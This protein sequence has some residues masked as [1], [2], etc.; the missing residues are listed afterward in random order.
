[1]LILKIKQ[2]NNNIKIFAL[3]DD[4]NDKTRVLDYGAD[5]F[6]TKPISPT[7]TVEKAMSLV[8]KKPA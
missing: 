6:S 7:T 3:A 5:E 1:M 8:M 2:I 4:E